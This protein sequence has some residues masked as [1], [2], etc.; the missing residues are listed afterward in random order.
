MLLS[1]TFIIWRWCKSKQ[2]IAFDSKGVLGDVVRSL[3][4][5]IVK[6]EIVDN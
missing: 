3:D 2:E 5:R 1:E 4:R 6:W